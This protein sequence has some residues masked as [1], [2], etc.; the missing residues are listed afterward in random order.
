MEFNIAVMSAEVVLTIFSII[1]IMHFC[2]NLF[3][4]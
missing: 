2:L 3:V 1:N 4:Y